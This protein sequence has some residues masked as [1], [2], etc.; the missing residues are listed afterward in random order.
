MEVAGVYEGE[1]RIVRRGLVESF[2][3]AA[4]LLE[5]FPRSL[6]G[7]GEE[8]VCLVELLCGPGDLGEEG[9][10]EP[11]FDARRHGPVDV[12]PYLVR[13]RVGERE[14]VAEGR[15]GLI[16]LSEPQISV[17][18]QEAGLLVVRR[19]HQYVF[20]LFGDRSE[21]RLSALERHRYAFQ[22]VL[23]IAVADR[24]LCPVDVER[25]GFVL[26]QRLD[27]PFQD[28]AGQAHTVGCERGL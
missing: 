23:E 19:R 9:G 2:E 5:R 18:E 6:L 10:E 24:H 16:L 20:E 4:E 1:L 3:R 7:R 26:G 28:L 12:F 14:A 21:I 17:R 27:G 15:D 13:V 22:G 11:R 25:R 8:L